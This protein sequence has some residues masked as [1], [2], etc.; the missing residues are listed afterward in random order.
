[1][2]SHTGLTNL[3]VVVAEACID[4][5]TAG[6]NFGMKFLGEFEQLVETFLR[7]HTITTGYHDSGTLQVMLRLF[8]MTVNHLYYIVCFRNILRNVV[9]H[10]FA[11][12]VFVEDFL[13][14]HTFANG[15]HLWTVFR[16]DDGSHDVTTE[17][18]TNLIQ[19]VFVSDAVLLVFVR[20]DF[21][22]CTVGS[23]TAGQSRR[24]ARAEVTT[25]NGC[26]HQA[27]LRLFFLEQ[28]HEDRSV[29]QGSI[30]EQARSIEH[31]KLVDTERQY[32]FFNS[33]KACTGSNGFQ[34]AA[35]LS[36]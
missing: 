22:L 23:Q 36:S 3:T 31:M 25:D 30:R 10:H 35:Q 24:N 2:N 6:T 8:Y 1:M 12:V 32:L 17:G 7:A 28:V 13:L 14:H 21:E 33:C 20:T 16:V 34:L 9:V 5:C 27:N 4:S 11:G 26:T 15:C 19:Q 29:R 18:R